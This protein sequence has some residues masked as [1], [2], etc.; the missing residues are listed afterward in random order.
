M[1]PVFPDPPCVR[2]LIC[3]EHG[4]GGEKKTQRTR[5]ST[6]T[7]MDTSWSSSLG[8]RRSSRAR[9]SCGIRS[10]CAKLNEEFRNLCYSH[11]PVVEA[12][13]DAAEPEFVA[14]ATALVAVVMYDEM[15][16][17]R[18]CEYFCVASAEPSPWSQFATQVVVWFMARASG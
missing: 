3:L 10:I 11:A 7:E 13:L 16:A 2:I 12:E 4:E 1:Q 14:W 15:Q 9:R 5:R 6:S 8:R 18:H 17:L